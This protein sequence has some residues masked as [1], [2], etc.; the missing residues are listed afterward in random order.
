[1]WYRQELVLRDFYVQI[2][3]MDGEGFFHGA[4]LGGLRPNIYLAGQG[5]TGKGSKYEGRGGALLR[6]LT[7]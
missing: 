1:M 3:D 4:R 2:R 6:V 5:G 7:D